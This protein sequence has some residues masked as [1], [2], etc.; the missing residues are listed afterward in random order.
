MSEDEVE[1]RTYLTLDLVEGDTGISRIYFDDAKLDF[2]TPMSG[3]FKVYCDKTKHTL[4]IFPTKNLF[5]ALWTTKE[6]PQNLSLC[7]K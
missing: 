3:L 2:D 4:G 1:T 5:G 7:V 6:M